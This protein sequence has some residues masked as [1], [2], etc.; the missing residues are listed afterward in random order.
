MIRNLTELEMNVI[1]EL[2]KGISSAEIAKVFKI[3]EYHV[4][5]IK[6]KN[7]IPNN[8]LIKLLLNN[9]D[10]KNEFEILYNNNTLEDVLYF[11][12]NHDLFKRHK[13]SKHIIT[14]IR[15]FYNI[16]LKQPENTYYSE[17][18]RIKGY[19]I[20]NSKFSAKRRN[21]EFNIHYSDFSLPE[22]CPLLNIKLTYGAESSGNHFS[23]A[24]LDRIDNTK[25]YLKDNVWVISRLANAMKNEATLEQLQTFC[26]NMLNNLTSLKNQGA[27]GDITS[28]SNN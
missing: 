3:S 27:L 19:M 11:L 20:R 18:D 8:K 14:K 13:L 7:N 2:R 9:L 28:I 22:Y 25:G 15:A 5:S 4:S 23:H 6:I 17:E 26:T 10:F 16:P 21:I 1:N 12:K 24:S